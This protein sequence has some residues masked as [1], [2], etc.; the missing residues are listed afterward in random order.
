MS[1]FA[2]SNYFDIAIFTLPTRDKDLG[3]LYNYFYEPGDITTSNKVNVTFIDVHAKQKVSIDTTV[4]RN[5]S[6][7]TKTLAITHELINGA[8]GS[9]VINNDNQIIGMVYTNKLYNNMSLCVPIDTIVNLIKR[10]RLKN[11]RI[12]K[13]INLDNEKIY[14]QMTT[15]PVPSNILEMLP[16][17][18]K[19]CEIVT[20]NETIKFKNIDGVYPLDIIQKVNDIHVGEYDFTSNICLTDREN[21]AKLNIIKLNKDWRDKYGSLPRKLL[22]KT[23]SKEIYEVANVRLEPVPEYY[24]A[25]NIVFNITEKNIDGDKIQFEIEEETLDLIYKYINVGARIKFL[26]GLKHIHQKD[27]FVIKDLNR[28]TNLL[29]IKLNKTILNTSN[30]IEFRVD[31]LQSS[32]AINLNTDKQLNINLNYESS[33]KTLYDEHT[34]IIM[35]IIW[36]LK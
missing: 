2:Y 4:V 26:K 12:N 18:I 24:S 9:A 6:L 20:M 17:N 35:N 29:K 7:P 14:P 31:L 23:D 22:F 11:F 27:Y 1:S 5:T 13:Q 8:S 30:N 32:Y 36:L 21:Y 28:T 3:D 15:I 16:N 34:L 10:Y 19:D 25:S 33:I